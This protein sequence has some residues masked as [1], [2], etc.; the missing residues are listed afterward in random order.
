MHRNVK[1]TLLFGLLA[2]LPLHAALAQEPARDKPSNREQLESLRPTGTVTVKADR[3]EWVQDNAMKY[4]GNV[5]FD[6]NTLSIRGDEMEVKQAAD[7]QFEAWIRGKPA[8]LDHAAD[9][10]AVGAAAQAVSAQAQQMHYDSRTGTIDLSGDAR[11][12]RGNNDVSGATIGYIVPERRIRASSG[13]SGQVTVTFEPPP[14]KAKADSAPTNN[15][16]KS[17]QP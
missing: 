2:G 6:S 3:A 12:K 8:V 5:K 11:L 13:G 4:A 17:E 14:P 16:K 15:N 7:G 1:R 10:K 9:P